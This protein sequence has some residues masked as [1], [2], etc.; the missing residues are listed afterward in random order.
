[1]KSILISMTL[2]L[3]ALN[4]SYAQTSFSCYYREYC[5]W[6]ES[7]EEFDDCEGYDESSLFEMNKDETMIIHTIENMKST[8]YVKDREYLETK[9]VWTYGVVSD[10]GN[11][12]LY[13]F[14]P[15][16][17][18]IRCLFKKNGK[19][20]LLRFYIKAVF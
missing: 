1:M 13:V 5:H 11:E 6:N 8:Y 16:N 12:Y 3:F 10:V 19:A 18:E 20:I 15:K 2:F 14:D 9:K 17:K 4:G 7:E